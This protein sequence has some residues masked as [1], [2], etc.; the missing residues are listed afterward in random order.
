[1]SNNYEEFLQRLNQYRL[2]LNMTQEETG[3]KLGINQ[4]QYSK[5]ELG[6][7]IVPY[8]TL[9]LLMKMGWDVDYLFTGKEAACH[10]SEL[11][12]LIAWGDEKDRRELL[13]AVAWLLKQ[14]V[15]K[16]VSGVSF[17]TRCEIE[18]LRMRASGGT[19]KSVLYKIRKIAGIA[20]IPMSEK[21]GVNI[22]KY[23]ML[24]KNEVDPDAELLL[25]IYEV[26]GCRPSLLLDDSNVE[27]MIIDD[28]WRQIDRP[29]Q[30][31]IKSLTEQVLWFLKM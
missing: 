1:M 30:M 9:E 23:R 19:S 26:T 2:R 16:S 8:R 21:L 25:R 11:G 22:K 28:L 6:K 15:E 10:T 31:K 4:S 27:G 14:G 3:R 20:Q 24:E 17:E 7:T 5:M 29:I 18:I 12:E 13:S